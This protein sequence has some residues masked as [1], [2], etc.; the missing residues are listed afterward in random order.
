LARSSMDYEV[1][2]I[3]LYEFGYKDNSQRFREHP[4]IGP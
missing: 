4:L 1:L 2:N 3:I